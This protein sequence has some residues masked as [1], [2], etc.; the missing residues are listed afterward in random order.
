MKR[1]I[2]TLTLA[3]GLAA[4]PVLAESGWKSSLSGLAP[5]PAAYGTELRRL[6]P[7]D[8]AAPLPADALAEGISEDWLM[9]RPAPEGDA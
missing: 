3:L 1:T 9:S 2:A 4:G 8:L 7:P 5:S 6:P